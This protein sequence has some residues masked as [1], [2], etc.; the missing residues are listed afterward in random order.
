MEFSIIDEKLIKVIEL[1]LNKEL[2]NLKKW[3]NG[4]E[5]LY[6]VYGEYDES[7]ISG[8]ERADKFDITEITRFDSNWIIHVII[9]SNVGDFNW[10]LLIYDMERKLESMFNV[11]IDITVDGY[12]WSHKEENEI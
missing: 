10:D 11:H 3:V 6:D 1:Y 2:V 4:I 7:Y 9:Y 8:I 12:K 5:N